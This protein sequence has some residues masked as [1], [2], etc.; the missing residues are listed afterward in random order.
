MTKKIFVLAA[1]TLLLAGCSTNQDMGNT[2]E[3]KL[4]DLGLLEE[5]IT[6]TTGDLPA[7]TT[8][9]KSGSGNKVIGSCNSIEAHSACI[10]YIGSIWTSQ[11]IAASCNSEQG[12]VF[13]P[14]ACP[15]DSVGGCQIGGGSDNEMVTWFYSFGA[16]PVGAGVVQYSAAACNAT[17]GA[18][19]IEAK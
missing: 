17:P 15:A 18:V 16:E 14:E 3:L 10:D 12:M 4:D 6:P 9:P 5:S 19:W 8:V 7:P 11:V 13:S 1:L 2:D